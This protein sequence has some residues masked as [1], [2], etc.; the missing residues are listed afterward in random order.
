MAWKQSTFRTKTHRK[1][2]LN[3]LSRGMLFTWLMLA[4]FILILAPQQWTNKFQFAFIRIFRW[5]LKIGSEISLAS[6]TQQQFTSS[7]NQTISQ[8]E[9]YI[10]N[11]E[12]SLEQANQTINQLSGL[13]NR[14]PL[15]KGA[16]LVPA[17]ITTVTISGTQAELIINRGTGE[18]LASNQF[19]IADNS[20]IGTIAEVSNRLARVKLFTDKSSNIAVKLGKLEVKRVMRGAGN[21]SAKILNLQTKHK[22]EAGD[23]VFAYKKPGFLDVPMIIGKVTR[24]KRDDQQPSIWDITVQPAC[25]ITKIDSVNVIIMNPR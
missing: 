4:G 1:S 12:Q 10:A 11:L 19:V 8:Y 18:G 17:D 22:V 20:I 3:S 16:K 21:N 6:P 9:N 5:P 24:C 2:I 25:D 23:Q 13:R 14:F 15:L 7:S